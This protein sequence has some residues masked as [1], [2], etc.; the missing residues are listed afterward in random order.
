MQGSSS[1][2][3]STCGVT[4][5]SNSLKSSSQ[6]KRRTCEHG[7]FRPYCKD[8]KGSMLC[9]HLRHKNRCGICKRSKCGT[10]N[11]VFVATTVYL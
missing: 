10:D 11:V 2:L 4:P 8:C 5:H 7:K 3:S 1:N 6:R 9:E